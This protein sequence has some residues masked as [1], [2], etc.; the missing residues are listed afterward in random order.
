MRPIR[1][2]VTNLELQAPRSWD[3]EKGECRPLPVARSEGIIY[4]YWKPTLWERVL[5][6]FGRPVRLGVMG[7]VH[8][9]VALE[10]APRLEAKP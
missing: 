9:P 3:H 7:R 5:L 10:A 2:Q 8:P 6:F 1:T 4:S